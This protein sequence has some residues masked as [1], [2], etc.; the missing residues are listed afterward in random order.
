M[1]G[2][3]EPGV[4]VLVIKKRYNPDSNVVFFLYRRATVYIIKLLIFF[5]VCFQSCDFGSM[6]CYRG[7]ECGCDDK[8][9]STY[10]WI[11]GTH[12][13]VRHLNKTVGESRYRSRVSFGFVF[14]GFNSYWCLWIGKEVPYPGIGQITSQDDIIQHSY[15]IWIYPWLALTIVLF[16]LPWWM[17]NKH[18]GGNRIKVFMEELDVIVVDDPD[19][20]NLK[21][22]RVLAYFCAQINTPI[23][24]SLAVRYI[25]CEIFNLLHVLG[26]MTFTDYLLNGGFSTYGLEVISFLRASQES[27]ID[28]MSRIFP[29]VTACLLN[30]IGPSGNE[31]L[32]EG[33]CV[34]PLNSLFEKIFVFLW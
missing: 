13:V 2:G 4:T 12:T 3:L 11:Q 14:A 28:P 1:D 8:F 16:R 25:F 34:L 19:K 22:D 21:K 7:G 5:I 17:W 30:L 24:T 23:H 15:Y 27:R 32:I 31:Q 20:V 10:C 26:Q 33:I 9:L 6:K 18:W 29:K